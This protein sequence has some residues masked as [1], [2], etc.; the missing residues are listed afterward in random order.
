[1]WYASPLIPYPTS[2]AITVA[3]RF[4][5]HLLGFVRV[6]G[7]VG[8]RDIRSRQRIELLCEHLHLFFLLTLGAFELLLQFL[9][10]ALQL[11]HFI[12][13]LRVHQRGAQAQSTIAS[14]KIS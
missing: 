7:G 14:G 12:C 8:W 9:Q 11:E 4:F 10:L 5:A 1:M 6:R 13:V 3:P 2:S